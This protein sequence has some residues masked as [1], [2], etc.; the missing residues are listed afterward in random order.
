VT[1]ANAEKLITVIG[2]S[3][4]VG[5]HL[6]RSLA[7]RGYRVRVASRRPDL[8]GFV[9]TQGSPGQI[10]LVQANVRYPASLA[11]ACEGAFA[12]INLTAV[13][14]NAGAQSF[15]AIHVFGADA[16]AKAAKAAKAQLFIHMSGLGTDLPSN[17][18]YVKSRAD[19]EARAKSAFANAIIMRPSI[20]FGPEDRFFNKF[21]QMARF[22]PIL[23]MIGSAT[24]FQPVFVGDVAEAMAIL[25]DRGTA[26]GK[27][28]EL[29]GPQQKSFKEL[30]QYLL[31]VI[32]RKRV[33]LPLPFPLA[34]VMGAVLGI[35][36]NPPI[37][38]DQVE[39]LKTDNLV[40]AKA[41]AEGLT[42]QGLGVTPRSIEAIVPS[43]LYRFRKAGQ[44]SVPNAAP[45]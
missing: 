3:G 27:V 34:S 10:A 21:A 43:Y 18:S 24:K 8:A 31:G 30:M 6:V 38:M 45:E 28:Y 7:R 22:S 23:P 5:R 12:V 44:F 4:F 17:S 37:S 1:T 29:G 2:G 13:F 33:L 19:G 15:D 25:V 41:I 40:S 11:A 36:P 39:L 26:N 42:L 16:A 35:L 32:Q 20:I 14:H 9:T